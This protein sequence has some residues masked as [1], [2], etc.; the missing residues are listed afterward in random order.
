MHRASGAMG[1]RVR[2]RPHPYVYLAT[3]AVRAAVLLPVVALAAIALTGSG[4]DW[5]HL[6]GNVLRGSMRSCVLVVVLVGA[7]WG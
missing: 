6:V 3:L 5:P 4:S 7:G 2:R 1:P